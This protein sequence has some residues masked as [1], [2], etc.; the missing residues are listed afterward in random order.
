[1]FDAPLSYSCHLSCEDNYGADWTM[2]HPDVLLSLPNGSV[3]LTCPKISAGRTK[4]RDDFSQWLHQWG[5]I[6]AVSG[7]WG[8]RHGCWQHKGQEE[9]SSPADGPGVSNQHR[10]DTDLEEWGSPDDD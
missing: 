7:A 3:F 6:E 9:L 2:G 10:Q 4:S 8:H 1:M 5:S